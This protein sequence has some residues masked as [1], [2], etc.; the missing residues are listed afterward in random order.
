VNT[1]PAEQPTLPSNPSE[2]PIARVVAE[3]AKEL[4]ETRYEPRCEVGRGG[5]GMVL[6]ALEKPLHRRVALKLLLRAGD[7]E[8]QKRFI[9]EAQITG[10][11]EHPSIVP[12]HEL[13][14]DEKGELFYTMK[15]VRGVTLLQIL[16][17]L[18]ARKA[19]LL[20]RYSLPSLL[21]VF[22]KVCDAIAFAHSQPEPV[23][24]RDL[25]PENIM[26]GDYGEVLVM[27]WGTAK[28][29]RV[30]RST[31]PLVTASPEAVEEIQTEDVISDILKTQ[32]GSVMGTPGYMA[33]EQAGGQTENADERTDIYALGAILY[34]LLTWE[35]PIRL[36][37][38]EA[39]DFGKRLQ[40]GEDITDAFHRHVAPLLS[41]R[42][43]R[44]RLSHTLG[45]PVPD[46][47]IHVVLKAMAVRPED[48]YP[49][50]QK[51]QADVAAYQSG[52]ATS[53]EEARAWKRFKLLVARNRILF[54]AIA[55]V[56]VILLTATTISLQQRQIALDSNAG[57]QIALQRAS[58]A[59]Q[60]AARQHFQNGEW[61]R[62]LALMGRALAFWPENRAAADYLLSAIVF[63]RRDSDKLPI[64]GVQHAG[65]VYEVDFSP[66]GSRFVTASYDHT[67]QVWDTATGAP[68]FKKPLQHSGP[69]NSARF[70]PDGHKIVTV[71]HDGFAHVWNARTGEP[72]LKPLR[73][74]KPELDESNVVETAVFSPDGKRVLTASWDHAARVWDAET[75]EQ[76]AELI[77]PNRVASATFS[78][79]GTRIVAS[80]WHG[81]A[82]LWH[83]TTFQPIAPP[84]PH[85]AT[86]RKAIFSPDGRRVATASLDKTARIWDAQTGR[87]L[88]APIQHRDM[89]WSLAISPDGLL[90]A[91][92]CYDKTARLWSLIDGSP[93]GTPMEHDGPV[94]TV[95]F[96]SDGAQLV[97]ASRDKTVRVWDTKTCQ[98][99]GE[100]MRHDDSVFKAIFTR[101]GSKVLSVS[102]DH[103][104]YLWDAKLPSW[105]G[106]VLSI[107]EPVRIAEFTEN[108]Q[109]VFIATS[110]GRAGIWSLTE[111]RFVSP[112]VDQNGSLV[113]AS[114]SLAKPVFATADSDGVVHFWNSASGAQLSRT[115][116]QDSDIAAIVFSPDGSYLFAAYVSGFVLQWRVADGT[117]T[118]KPIRH[119][120]KMGA[121]AVAPAGNEI[122]TACLDTFLHFWD[123]RT[124]T[125]TRP[126]IRHGD[127]VLAI[128]YSPDGRSI[129]TGCGDHTARIWSLQTG[130]Q[131]GA[132]LLLKS[133][134]TTVRH[135][136]DGRGLLAAGREDREVTVYDTTTRMPVHPALPHA[137]G[138]VHATISCDGSEI[139]TVAADGTARLWPMRSASV[140][141]PKW[142]ADYLRAL[143]GLS[144]SAEQQFVQVPT[145]E[146]LRLRQQL[147]Q[148]VHDSSG[149]NALMRWSF[150]QDRSA[151][152]DR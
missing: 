37:S 89:V 72:L 101:D 87:P 11:L 122:A 27:D 151:A 29:L 126:D 61:R 112:I 17:D 86:V 19:E 147:L 59:D 45:R 132:A 134:V 146:R 152:P 110:D 77:H 15:L 93:V 39:Q 22:Q 121:L 60:E 73:H 97:T 107:P 9:R 150:E 53:A 84:M 69:V 109:T 38:A 51:L 75:G 116:K 124:G 137:Q 32:A 62:G 111:N 65:P 54:S 136:A 127:P 105:P 50:V 23:I 70:S 4:N 104:A 3:L 76:L 40:D 2:T 74:G 139:V 82:M 149:W 80:Y 18:G 55:T 96:S 83:A 78:P 5:M 66:D 67:A 133:P 21:T 12:V 144:F 119:S 8:S 26:I 118:G 88:C 140:P 36:T 130:K 30:D 148:N 25:K 41:A 56:L 102:W 100:P 52:F 43:K 123:P 46:S 85:S 128:N 57:L 125:P 113:T 138:I 108:A 117:I 98:P 47:L 44:Q 142:L 131:V 81:G 103:A 94:D 14:L 64:F 42:S 16:Q 31:K 24:H 79:D 129:A 6:E 145:A 13:N 143:G 91:T 99:I 68:L 34:A 106:E 115:S 63:G 92:A 35:A 20:R 58:R 48:R 120:E 114:I 33:P 28:I 7:E 1:P 49:T 135:I 95:A 10:A 90:L 71:T 141:P